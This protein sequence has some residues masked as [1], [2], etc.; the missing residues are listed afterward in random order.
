MAEVRSFKKTV[1]TATTAEALQAST[2]KVR[3]A[4]IKALSTNTGLA[5]IGDSAV[6]AANGFELAAGESVGIGAIMTRGNHGTYDLNK[7]YADVATSGEGV[8]VLYN[9]EEDEDPA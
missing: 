2:F 3:N 6:A 5:Y 8:C 9:F 7:I 4:V 1:T